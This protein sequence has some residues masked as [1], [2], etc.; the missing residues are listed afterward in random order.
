MKTKTDQFEKHILQMAEQE[1]MILPETLYRKVDDVLVSLPE[2]NRTCKMTWRKSIILAAA[3]AAL[4][5]VTVTA[6]VGAWQQ[7]MEAMNA[8]EIEEYFTQ[9]YKSKLGMD[10]Y[11]RPY[12]DK[13]RKRREELCTAYE[14]EAVFPQR[15][16]TMISAP[17]E[18][19][20][21]G[22]AFYKDTSTFFF[23]EEEMSDE[24]LLQIIDFMHRR[25]YSLQVMNE[26]I[27]ADET[28]FPSERITEKKINEEK[29]SAM[30]TDHTPAR[31]EASEG[32][33]GETQNPEQ[34]LTIP[35]TG[36]LEIRKIA[37]GQSGIF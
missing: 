15:E 37:A 35:Y 21:K 27:A 8:Q 20:G 19:K 22:V 3:L 1:K 28:A 13:E 29:E 31:E 14:Q 23:P 26:K 11:N 33:G 30:E 17:E 2:R 24:E 4:C 10:N 7:R 25:D 12:T 9:I 6:A 18:Y 34:N 32:N 36:D 16:L 5:S